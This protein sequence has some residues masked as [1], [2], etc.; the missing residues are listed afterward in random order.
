MFILYVTTNKQNQNSMSR[1]TAKAIATY[2]RES[3]YMKPGVDFWSTLSLDN[4]QKFRTFITR[5]RPGIA[6]GTHEERLAAF[7][8]LMPEHLGRDTAQQWASDPKLK[9]FLVSAN[10]RPRPPEIHGEKGLGKT[11]GNSYRI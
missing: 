7:T 5:V 1:L 4:K 8:A 6:S 10:K 2:F 3:G 9:H 11:A